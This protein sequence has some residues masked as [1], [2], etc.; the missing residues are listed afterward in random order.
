M[1]CIEDICISCHCFL[2][3]LPCIPGTDAMEYLQC[4]MGVF[5]NINLGTYVAFE[6]LSS[7][8]IT[9]NSELLCEKSTL[10]ILAV[11]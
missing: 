4:N 8:D 7:M 2:F 10:S 3:S 9:G 5:E 6:R 11:Q 1:L